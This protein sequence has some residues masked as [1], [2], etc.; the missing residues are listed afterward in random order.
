MAV[1]RREEMANSEEDDGA[2]IRTM[3]VMGFHWSFD[4]G[5]AHTA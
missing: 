5:E 4:E 2:E 3:A 1:V